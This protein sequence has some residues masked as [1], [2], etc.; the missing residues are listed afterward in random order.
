MSEL[1][2]IHTKLRKTQI[3]NFETINILK[4]LLFLKKQLLK[5]NKHFSSLQFEKEK[6]GRKQKIKSAL[7]QEKKSKV[8]VLNPRVKKTFRQIK[9]QPKENKQYEA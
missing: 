4:L 9:K 6:L 5:D 8:S 7:F 2:S 3:C 1:F